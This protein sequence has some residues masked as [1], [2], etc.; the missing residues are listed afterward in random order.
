MIYPSTIQIETSGVCNAACS[1]CPHSTMNRT[2]Q[3]KM[4]PELFSAIV[5]ELASWP[6]HPPYICP[7]LTNEPFADPRIYGFCREINEKLP[8]TKLVFFTNG[9]LFTPGNLEKLATVR[10]IQTI[11]V[12]LHHGSAED[13]KADLQLDF[14]R[15][16]ESVQRLIASNIAPVKLLRVQNDDAN[17]DMQFLDFCKATFPSTP[18]CLSYRYNWKGEID[19]PFSYI[20][21]LD[22]KCPRHS[23][24]TILCDG[25]VALCCMDERGDYALG[26]FPEQTLADIYNGPL[27]TGYR[28]RTKRHSTP[29]NLCNMRG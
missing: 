17:K 18:A 3:D 22:I 5:D 29:C 26:K 25:R 28:E 24:M 27:A 11:H 9:S 1:F 2:A 7:F 15:T 14:Q 4:P 16:V 10:N 23:S 8:S 21:T 19:S 12:S 13:Y 20:N 6:L